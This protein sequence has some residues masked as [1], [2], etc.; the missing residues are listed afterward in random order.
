MTVNQRTNLAKSQINCRTHVKM[1]FYNDC[2]TMLI[3]PETSA[4]YEAIAY[5]EEQACGLNEANLVQA[6]RSH[7]KVILSLVGVFRE[8]VVGHILF[9]PVAIETPKG[10]IDAVG[11]GPLG[12]LPQFQRQ[13]IGSAL[14]RHGLEALRKD[15]YA[16]VVVLGHPNFYSRFG[17]SASVAYGIK[18]Q[19][20]VP[21]DVFMVTELV[22]GALNGKSGTVVYA[23]EFNSV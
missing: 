13:G 4:D 14:V 7:Q 2:S 15:N 18:S 1:D 12:V 11:L 22:L 23:P 5:V 9:S 10:A 16:A 17:F 21:D 20:N 6:L 8:Q 3:R 19:Y